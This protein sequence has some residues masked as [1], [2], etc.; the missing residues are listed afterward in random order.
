MI[1]LLAAGVLAQAVQTKEGTP[2]QAIVAMHRLAACLVQNR[3][4]QVV[5]MLQQ[6]PSSAAEQS[7]AR[8]L[9]A[10]A[11]DCLGDAAGEMVQGEGAT[12][13]QMRFPSS[14]LMRGPLFE[15]LY[16]QDFENFALRR[17]RTPLPLPDLDAMEKTPDLSDHSK[18]SLAVDDFAACVVAANPAES[19]ALLETAPA[20]SDE[21]KHVDALTPALGPCFAKGIQFSINHP[22]LRGFVA[23]AAYR[24]ASVV[25]GGRR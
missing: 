3:R 16:K 18:R 22:M 13:L 14:A 9:A 12:T 19:L 1:V 24:R 2:Q 6:I 8:A 17:G 25:Q 21:E 23:E 4:R 5:T 7:A 20:S 10:A 11:Q 15:A